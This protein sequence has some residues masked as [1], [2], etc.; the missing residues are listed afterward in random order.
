M[1]VAAALGPNSRFVVRCAARLFLHA[2]DT[3]KALSVIRK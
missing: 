1:T 3:R 2:H